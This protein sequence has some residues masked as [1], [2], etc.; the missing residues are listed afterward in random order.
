MLHGRVVRPRGQAGYGSGAPILAVDERSVQ[1]IPGVRVVR[2]GDFLG[3]VAPQEYD[4]IQAAAQ[5]K[6]TWKDTPILPT[7]GNLWKRMRQQ[8]SAGLAPARITQQA[9]D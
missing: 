7:T 2:A 3:V 8:D 6:V 1:H 4:A 9:G 5:L